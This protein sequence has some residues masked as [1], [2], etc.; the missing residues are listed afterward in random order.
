MDVVP[1]HHTPPTGAALVHHLRDRLFWYALA[2]MGGGW[3]LGM[4]GAAQAKA[5]AP[6]LA[7]VMNVL[8]FL[9]IFP[10]MIGLNFASCPRCSSSR[11]RCC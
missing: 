1:T 9:M 11:A 8:V 7:A 6:A 5:W 3:L 10:M 4:L 2:A